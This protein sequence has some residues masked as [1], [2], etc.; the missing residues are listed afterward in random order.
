[1]HLF[2]VSLAGRLQPQGS[3]RTEGGLSKCRHYATERLAFGSGGDPRAC[4]SRAR[5]SRGAELRGERT[6]LRDVNVVDGCLTRRQRP[7][8]AGR[9]SGCEVLEVDLRD[10]DQ[11]GTPIYVIELSPDDEKNNRDSIRTELSL[12]LGAIVPLFWLF[13]CIRINGGFHYTA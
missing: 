6:L 10:S 2:V 4:F 11:L 5:G 12:G 7:L 8:R 3:Q 13:T 1:M 9:P